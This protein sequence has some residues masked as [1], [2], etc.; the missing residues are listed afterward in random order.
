MLLTYIVNPKTTNIQCITNINPPK[1]CGHII[2]FYFYLLVYMHAIYPTAPAIRVVL[3]P[4]LWASS[5][6]VVV[7]A[8]V[9]CAHD[10]VDLS[11][12][13]P[14]F[15][16]APVFHSVP[17][18]Y[19]VIL[20]FLSCTWRCCLY[21]VKILISGQVWRQMDL[22]KPRKVHWHDKLYLELGNKSNKPAVYWN[23][24]WS[25]ATA[26][27]HSAFTCGLQLCDGQLPSIVIDQLLLF[28]V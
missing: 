9:V 23:V 17:V 11:D 28:I 22:L 13:L 21:F 8:D 19:D 12:N 5:D 25:Q 4:S 1:F 14:I 20:C 7:V 6:G 26:L 16:F 24:V 15:L 2:M 3:V 10:D 18:R 27:L